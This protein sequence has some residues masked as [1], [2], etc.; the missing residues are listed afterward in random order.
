MDPSTALTVLERLATRRNACTAFLVQAVEAHHS[1]FPL[2]IDLAPQCDPGT[3]DRAL[4]TVIGRWSDR[5]GCRYHNLLPQETTALRE[6][7]LEI[8]KRCYQVLGHQRDAAHYDETLAS[9]GG[10]YVTRLSEA[11]R[12]QEARDIANDLVDH[13]RC[14]Q[15]SSCVDQTTRYAASQFALGIALQR[16]GKYEEAAVANGEAVRAYRSL[17]EGL[18]SRYDWELAIALS[19]LAGNLSATGESTD[20][21]AAVD[22][23]ITVLARIAEASGERSTAVRA[24]CGSALGVKVNVLVQLGDY[25]SALEAGEGAVQTFA[26]LREDSPDRYAHHWAQALTNLAMVHS[27]LHHPNHA[28]AYIEQAALEF[29][30]MLVT[31]AGAFRL[32]HATVYTGLAKARA[33]TGDLPGALLAAEIALGDYKLLSASNADLA[34]PLLEALGHFLQLRGATKAGQPAREEIQDA[35]NTLM[36]K[37]A[38]GP[39]NSAAT[40]LDGLNALVE[41]LS[42]EGRTDEAQVMRE[43]IESFAVE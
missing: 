30:R 11:G 33:A 2:A 34:G 21:L 5:Q 24:A 26:P 1:L 32:E 35:V 22:E 7:S 6:T 23:A 39:S 42:R 40:L 8:T 31:H 9:V 41:W 12:H 28:C 4:A 25:E 20:A 18:P 29:D 3:I 15:A 10:N 16:L 38:A 36:R 37:I 14:K 27:R 17:N 43:Q 13:F 19:N